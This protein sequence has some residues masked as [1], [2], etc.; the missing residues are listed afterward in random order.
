MM[1]VGEYFSCAILDTGTIKCWGNGLF[2]QLGN[3]SPLTVGI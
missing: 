1:N 2:G 3:G